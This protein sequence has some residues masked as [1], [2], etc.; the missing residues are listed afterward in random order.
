MFLFFILTSSFRFYVKI[1]EKNVKEKNLPL[2]KLIPVLLTLLFLF[3][4]CSAALQ[5]KEYYSEPLDSSAIEKEILKWINS[6]RKKRSLPEVQLN[7]K[8]SSL[9]RD[10]SQDMIQM[11]L[12]DKLSHISSD[13]RTYTERLIQ[14]GFY[15]SANGENVAYSETFY[16][17]YIHNSLMESPQHRENILNPEFDQVGIG[18]VYNNDDGYYVTQD[19]IRSVQLLSEEEIQSYLLRRINGERSKKD[20]PL[21]EL[22][23]GLNDLASEFSIQK[24]SG[25]KN[26]KIPQT[27]FSVRIASIVSS[28]LQD[29]VPKLEDIENSEHD[30]G[31]IGAAFSRDTEYPGGA[32][33]ITLLLLIE[34]KYKKMS[35][36][37]QRGIVLEKVNELRKA[38]DLA[39]LK[40]DRRFSRAAEGFT[41]LAIAKQESLF[42]FP[43]ELVNRKVLSYF[44]EDLALLPAQTEEIIKRGRL[45]K[46]GIGII[47]K[48]D[49][50]FPRG[51]F[52]I[53]IIY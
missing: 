28:S 52:W 29:A 36:D 10:H 39:S 32:Y 5:E 48:K 41:R 53:T 42:V 24:A 31:G 7:P 30:R 13:G 51:N 17:E 27:L 6:E 20:L 4:P 3:L 23:K 49:E 35:M 15:F 50:E 12:E 45:R 25:E 11:E 47:F 14:A 43:P 2:Q 21:L 37:E 19:F 18:V 1:K 16:P 34:N 46:I 44:T 40:L 26:P 8:L 33:F 9:A 22:E 38:N